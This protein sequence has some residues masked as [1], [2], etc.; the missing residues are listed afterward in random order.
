MRPAVKKSV[1]VPASNKVKSTQSLN[2]NSSRSLSGKDSVSA[3]PQKE[4]GPTK[5]DISGTHRTSPGQVARPAIKKA[6]PVQ[7]PAESQQGPYSKNDSTALPSAKEVCLQNS[8]LVSIEAVA[9]KLQTLQSNNN[10]PQTQEEAPVTVLKSIYNDSRSSSR[11]PAK[12]VNFSSTFKGGRR[13]HQESTD[14]P[15]K[16]SRIPRLSSATS[17]ASMLTRDNASPVPVRFTSVL[18]AS[19]DDEVGAKETV[20]TSGSKRGR[21]VNRKVHVRPLRASS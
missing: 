2:N 19:D 5:Q 1:P 14:D 20:D 7:L 15:L 21:I 17:P 3:S 11:S 8:S 9:T 18:H 12:K 10:Q 6:A 4:S 13:V 16:N